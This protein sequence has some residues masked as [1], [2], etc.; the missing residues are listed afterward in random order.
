MWPQNVNQTS[1]MTQA[2]KNQNDTILPT[3]TTLSLED[4]GS[5]WHRE[6]LG[7]GEV[8]TNTLREQRIAASFY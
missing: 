1:E 4:V 5:E 6:Q 3:R 2:E 7:A 8:V